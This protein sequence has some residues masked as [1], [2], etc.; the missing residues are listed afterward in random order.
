[1]L[2]M[3]LVVAR[4]ASGQSFELSASAGPTITDAGSSIAAGV[5]FG[6]TS[7]LT[8]FANIERTHL[9]SRTTR[10][11]GVISSF[12]GG[13]FLLASAEL[14]F[15]PFGRDR[16]GPFGLAGVAAGA[17]RP[18]VTELFP[19]PVTNSMRGLFVGGGLLLPMSAR[20]T[21]FADTRML[22]GLDGS[23]GMAVG[24]LRAGANWR[25]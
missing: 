23:E 10:N 3:A 1:M 24:T 6:P 16:V 18:N 9:V 4:A 2:V 15:A 5:G 20:L 8:L 22:L 7:R 25:F 13:T 14:R 17:S 21:A 12:R 11:E 19:T